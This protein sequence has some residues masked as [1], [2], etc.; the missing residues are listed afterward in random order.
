ML[1]FRAD[2]EKFRSWVGIILPWAGLGAIFVGVAWFASVP[3]ALIAIGSI[4][5][6]DCTIGAVL[7][8]RSAK[9]PDT[10]PRD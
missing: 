9:H 8:G 7:S 6:L 1:L 10:P 5:W 3:L 2:A 4:V